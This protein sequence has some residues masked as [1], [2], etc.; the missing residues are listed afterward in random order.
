[1]KSL[2]PLIEVTALFLKLGTIGFG[3]PA[4]TIAMMEEE[5]VERR[6][7]LSHQQFLDLVGMTNL[8]PGPNAVEMALHLGLLRAGWLGF[9][10]AGLAFIFPAAIISLFFAWMYVHL[11]T[12]ANLGPLFFGI[13]PAVIAVIAISVWRLGK[14]AVKSPSLLAIGVLV[15]A[16]AFLGMDEVTAM[17]VG[18][19]VG[20]FWLRA[21]RA[22][23]IVSPLLLLP[24]PYG[25]AGGLRTG[26]LKATVVTGVSVTAGVT[27]WKLGLFFLKV[28]AVLY[29]SGY[30][31]VAFLQDG[32]VRQYGWLTQEQ[33]L[34]AIAVGQFTPGPLLSTATFIGYVLLGNR[35]A[36]VATIA[37]F[38]PSF[39]FVPALYRAM[40]HIR[41]SLWAAAFLDSI[42]VSSIALMAVVGVRLGRQTL[43]T[44]TAW[45][46]LATATAVSLRWK[47]NP[48]WLVVGGAIAGLLLIHLA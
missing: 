1:M 36:V 21:S 38:L 23:S 15:A 33:L 32:L 10:L 28:G 9:L 40:P 43:T 11:G 19:I 6:K 46:I 22:P 27:L 30:V 48:V 20:M 7:W 31:L 8:I 29:G 25:S 24:A 37:V 5:V 18:A 41:R 4:A 3:G 34:D 47:V 26:L 35:G 45:V 13:R 44:W 14:N 17:F 12:K 42:N 16:A 2:R 39:V